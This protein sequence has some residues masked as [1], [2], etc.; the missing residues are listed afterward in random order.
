MDK[1]NDLVSQIPDDLLKALRRLE[2]SVSN[3]RKGDCL[4]TEDKRLQLCK[5][6]R[7]KLYISLLWE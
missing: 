5:K 1:I 6:R 4:M 3:A 7:N 2:N